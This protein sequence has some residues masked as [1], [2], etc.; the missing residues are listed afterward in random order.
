MRLEKC[1]EAEGYYFVMDIETCKVEQLKLQEMIEKTKNG[2]IVNSKIVGNTM[3][4]YYKNMEIK[5]ELE[6]VDVTVIGQ[7]DNYDL[8]GEMYVYIDCDGEIGVVSK[9]RAELKQTPYDIETIRLNNDKMIA[10]VRQINAVNEMLSVPL[11]ISVCDINMQAYLDYSWGM[12]RQ[13]TVSIRI[14]EGVKSVGRAQSSEKLKA[15]VELK[16]PQ[17]LVRI[18]QGTFELARIE[19]AN[20]ENIK[21][22]EAFAFEKSRI[23]CDVIINDLKEIEEEAFIDATV[24]KMHIGRL[25]LV[26]N[27]AFGGLNANKLEIGQ[28]TTCIE[29]ER[30]GIYESNIKELEVEQLKCSVYCTR[31]D[32]KLMREDKIKR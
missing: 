1:E 10:E 11:K 5:N 32:C 28:A 18:K 24:N 23:N 26:D 31:T 29:G 9:E 3:E 7:T 12:N 8:A 30:S 27:E 15:R 22:I 21:V 6:E 4:V 2:E 20:F 25:G 13:E 17:S 19:Q 16:L 14:P